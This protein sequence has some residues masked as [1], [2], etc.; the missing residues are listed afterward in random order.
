M[1]TIF[2][3][4]FMGCGKTTVGKALADRLGFNQRAGFSF[5]DLDE[6]IASRERRSVKDI[7]AIDGE[8]Y[9]RSLEKKSM[10]EIAS[11]GGVVSLGGGTLLSPENAKIA[12]ICGKIV[13]LQAPFHVCYDRVMA[14][15]MGASRP[16]FSKYSYNELEQIYMERDEIYS[17]KANYVI[18]AD[19][20]VDN[21]VNT[22]VSKVTRYNH[23]ERR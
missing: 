7:F 23:P 2:L 11:S 21:I 17:R 14:Q 8:P 16:L 15:D 13:Y 6:Y 4:G 9:F 19:D 10:L 22:I 3:C 18:N 20:D 1:V 12:K 5:I